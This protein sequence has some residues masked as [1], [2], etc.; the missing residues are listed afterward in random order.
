MRNL[1]I[2]EYIINLI[3]LLFFYMHMFQLNSYFFAKHTHWIKENIKRIILQTLV[4]IFTG[5]ALIFNNVVINIVIIFILGFTIFYNI[6]KNKAKIKF[7]ITNRVK[8][9]L[10][11]EV[12]LIL[13][14]FLVNY[15]NF[16]IIKLIILNVFSP[17][18]CV[19]ANF[20]NYPI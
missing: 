13:A 15:N 16:F 9:M 17:I 14:V 11:T 5:I 4:I 12:I 19:I 18:F 2:I 20:I 10:F 3:I 8:R 7:N 1:I 6:P